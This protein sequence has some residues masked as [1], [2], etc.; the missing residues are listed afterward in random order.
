MF[1]QWRIKKLVNRIEQTTRDLSIVRDFKKL[2]DK[3]K[4]YYDDKWSEYSS[5]LAYKEE[6]LLID[7]KDAVR[8]LRHLDPNNSTLWVIS[9]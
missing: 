4:L 5:D 2:S 7:L 3:E 9:E 6:I 1:R 8:A